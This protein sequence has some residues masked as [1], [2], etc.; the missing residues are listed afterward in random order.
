MKINVLMQQTVQAAAKADE[1][2]AEAVKA[3]AEADEAAAA[4]A[5]ACSSQC[6]KYSNC[7]S[8]AQ[9]QSMNYLKPNQRLSTK[10]SIKHIEIKQTFACVKK[11]KV[12]LFEYLC[13]FFYLSVM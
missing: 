12:F 13:T 2:A 11:E 4:E 7:F 1:A 3:A 10:R 6:T 9:T 8:K 5:A